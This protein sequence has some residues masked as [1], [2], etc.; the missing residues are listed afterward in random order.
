MTNDHTLGDLVTEFLPC[1][2]FNQR[3]A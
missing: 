1:D 2:P 3:T